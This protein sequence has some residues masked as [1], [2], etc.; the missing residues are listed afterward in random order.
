MVCLVS[1]ERG[2]RKSRKVSPRAWKSEKDFQ[3]KD[4]VTPSVMRGVI[5]GRQT[6]ETV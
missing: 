1:W 4:T 2:P 5:G 6:L 3:T